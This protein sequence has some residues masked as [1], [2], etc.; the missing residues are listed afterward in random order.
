MTTHSND[1]LPAQA[2]KARRIHWNLV[3]L[4]AGLITVICAAVIITDI[5]SPRSRHPATA[6]TSTQP[7]TRP[8]ALP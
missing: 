4:L 1:A 7:A 8:G 5:L 3:L 2:P 6:A